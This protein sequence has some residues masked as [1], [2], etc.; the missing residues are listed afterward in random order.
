LLPDDRY[1]GPAPTRRKPPRPIGDRQRRRL[2]RS[3]RLLAHRA[4]EPE[5]RFRHRM[6]VLLHSRAAAVRTAVLEIAD[7]IEQSEDP[8]P[9]CCAELWALLRDGCE[10]PLYNSQVHES[11]LLAT[12]YYVRERLLAH[13]PST[14]SA[15]RTG[16]AR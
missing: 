9:A 11:E 13:S 8:D 12:L 5:D 16:S 14:R 6:E 3:L 2:V 7:L 15:P 10:S 1:E 4:L